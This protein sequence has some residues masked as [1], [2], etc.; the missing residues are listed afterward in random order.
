MCVS[1]DNN[2]NITRREYE[3]V[4]EEGLYSVLKLDIDEDAE[5]VGAKKFNEH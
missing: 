1:Y 4:A 3:A 2:K 5:A